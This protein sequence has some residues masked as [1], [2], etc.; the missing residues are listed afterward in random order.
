M[1][2]HRDILSI[3]YRLLVSYYKILFVFVYETYFTVAEFK[4]WVLSS[5]VALKFSIIIDITFV[6]E[7]RIRLDPSKL[8]V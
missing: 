7:K 4:S 6:H 5:I 1:F 2:Y 8:F 3:N